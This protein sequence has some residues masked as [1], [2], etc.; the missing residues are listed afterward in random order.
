MAIGGSIFPH[1]RIHKVTWVSP[2]HYTENQIDY[3]CI[4]KKFRRSVQG[5]RVYRGANMAS[6]HH[7]VVVTLR[8]KLKKLPN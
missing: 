1:K 3:I 6:D 4:N 5:V 7:L 8:L 2:D